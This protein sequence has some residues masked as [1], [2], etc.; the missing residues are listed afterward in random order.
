MAN[1]KVLSIEIGS[2]L[3]R[4]AEVD[5][6]VK[7]PKIYRTVVMATPEGIMNDGVL[8]VT[9]EFVK[10]LKSKISQNGMKSKQVVFTLTSTKIASREI[11]IPKVKEN[12]IAALVDA[13]ASDYFPV[14]LS[15]YELAHLVLDTVR[16]TVDSEKY[17]VMVM[18]I[19]KSLLENYENLAKEC[20]LSIAAIDYSGNSL[21][22]MVKKECSQGVTMV[23]RIDEGTSMVTILND[24]TMVMQRSV[25]YG[26]NEVVNCYLSELGE[27]DTFENALKALGSKNYFEIAKEEAADA[28]AAETAQKFGFAFS[29][30]V[31][32]I[33]RIFDY[34]NSRNLEKPINKVYLTGLGANIKGIREILSE[35]MGI[36]V[37]QLEVSGE[38]QSEKGIAAK[39]LNE[40]IDCL[41]APLAPLK[42]IDKQKEKKEKDSRSFMEANATKILIG[43]VALSLIILVVGLIPFVIENSQNGK[44]RARIEEL[45]EVVPVYQ[46]YVMTKN[47][48]N[49]LN[50]AYE[51]TVLPTETLVDFIEEMENKMPK[52]MYVTAFSANR[53]GVSFSVVAG[54]KQQ[55]AD[56][57]LQL[58][59]F[60]SLK[61]INVTEISDSRGDG[62]SGKVEFAVSA[63]YVNGKKAVMA[64]TADSSDA[65]ATAGDAE[66]MQ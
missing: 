51:Y 62:D 56:A 41:G 61:N 65:E 55:A 35:R 30:T 21:Y 42:A 45:G 22:Q 39:K 36:N 24:A 31:V 28:K 4:I 14:D 47:A 43:C 40:Y 20:G 13:N 5:Y 48:A 34:H 25:S 57:M 27:K 33:S 29:D 37:E 11:M 53:E 32:G 6:K 2:R 8:K 7:N 9:P 60:E 3:T 63:D 54:T 15:E 26:I 23:V 64:E 16:E 50:E 12:R 59:T 66:L 10:E 58:R 18:A 1:K 38:Y 49:Y 19:P 44:K 52:G 46:E 17:K